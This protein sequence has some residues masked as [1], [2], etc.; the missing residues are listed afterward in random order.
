MW[1]ALLAALTLH[2]CTAVVMA[3][4]TAAQ[5]A[6]E[7]RSLHDPAVVIDLHADVVYA[8]AVRGRDFA[9]GDGAWTIARAREGGLDAQ[10]FP[11]FVPADEPD[12]PG[13]LKREE[14]TLLE[15]IDGSGG[16]LA[17]VRT[18]AEIRERAAAG[19]ISALMGIE[20]AEALGDDPAAVEPYAES[21]LRYLGLTWNHSNAFAEAALD[22]RSPS[23]LTDAGRDLVGRCNDGGVLV[24]LAH[25][26]TA[27]FWD[28]FRASRAPLLVSHAGLDA[29]HRHNRNIDDL[30]LLALARTGGVLGIVFHSGF[31]TELPEGQETAPLDVLISHFEH[32]R[33]IGAA[34]ALALGSDF[35]GG[36][37]PPEGLATV[38]DL[39][40]VTAALRAR[41]WSDDEIRGA[42]GENVLRLLDAAD[43]AAG[44]EALERE[45]PLEV[46]C[47]IG[48]EAKRCDEWTDRLILPGPAVGPDEA[49]SIRPRRE[50]GGEPAAIEIWGQPDARLEATWTTPG[51]DP[52]AAPVAFD[53]SGHVRVDAPG[54]ARTVI[55]RVLDAPVR[56]DEIAVWARAR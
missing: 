28:A 35:D 37:H 53:G 18:A 33:S 43:A 32:A 30:Q 2:V 22:P 11:L 50:A 47:E 19:A 49:I 54:S 41:G 26:S 4:R 14:R 31:L 39:P 52:P 6:S 10:F 8:V 5:A 24:D 13:A 9:T 34:D 12:K 1:M 46:A 27:T 15:M 7:V 17:L 29:I 44:G 42:L 36:I 40:V 51:D 23:G 20:G 45:W 48:A 21:G 16:A 25:A 38:S 3:A 56:L 55:L